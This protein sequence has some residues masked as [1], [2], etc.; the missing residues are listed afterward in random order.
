MLSSFSNKVSEEVCPSAA[1]LPQPSAAKDAWAPASSDKVVKLA[2]NAICVYRGACRRYA[3]R[4]D[5]VDP[6]CLSSLL[7]A[8]QQLPSSQPSAANLGQALAILYGVVA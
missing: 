5:C 2:T 8:L 1:G 4:C 6:L 3:S 7:P